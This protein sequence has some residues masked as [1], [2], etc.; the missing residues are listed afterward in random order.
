MPVGQKVTRQAAALVPGIVA[1]GVGWVA[2]SLVSLGGVTDGGQSA[3]AA[4]KGGWD[5]A[6]HWAKGKVDARF[7]KKPGA[8]DQRKA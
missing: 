5:G 2:G 3:A 8:D 4:A 7:Q 1:A 6:R